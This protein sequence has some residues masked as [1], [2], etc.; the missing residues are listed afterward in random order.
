MKTR[1]TSVSTRRSQTKSITITLPSWTRSVALFT[2]LCLAIVVAGC[3]G[4]TQPGGGDAQQQSQTQNNNAAQTLSSRYGPI[5]L[6]NSNELANQKMRYERLNSPT[7]IGYIYVF[8]YGLVYGPYQVKGKCS[9]TE[10]LYTSPVNVDYKTEGTN[11]VASAVYPAAQP[12][13]SYG[14]NEAAIYCFLDDSNQTMME[15]NTNWIWVEKPITGFNTVQ[16]SAVIPNG[17]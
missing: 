2:L 14:Q 5:T 15:F 13:G 10:S 6:T 17:K 1:R 11:G 3:A 9:S 7:E 8:T 12:D 4:D 16:G